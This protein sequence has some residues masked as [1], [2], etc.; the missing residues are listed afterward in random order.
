MFKIMFVFFVHKF[1]NGTKTMLRRVTF[2]GWDVTNSLIRLGLL[3]EVASCGC[4]RRPSLAVVS[5]ARL[6]F[7]VNLSCPAVDN[8]V[9]SGMNFGLAHDD[10]SASTQ[11]VRFVRDCP[12]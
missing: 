4:M 9:D 6:P 7:A 8:V 2:V 10:G 1:E 5:A 11:I 12:P 3:E